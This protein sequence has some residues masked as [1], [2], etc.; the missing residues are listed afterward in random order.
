VQELELQ[1]MGLILLQV[2]V[3]RW[4]LPDR[5]QVVE[6]VVTS[7]TSSDKLHLLFLLDEGQQGSKAQRDE[8]TLHRQFL[9]VKVRRAMVQA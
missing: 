3:E 8:H 9:R 6:V 4:V 2:L 1:E 7:L 5:R